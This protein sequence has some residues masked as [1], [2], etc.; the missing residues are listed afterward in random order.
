MKRITEAFGL[1]AGCPPLVRTDFAAQRL[2]GIL[3]LVTGSVE[4]PLD[5]RETKLNPLLGDGV[6]PFF[7]G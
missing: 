7:G 3:L 6:M 5:R 1:K 2:Q 4:P